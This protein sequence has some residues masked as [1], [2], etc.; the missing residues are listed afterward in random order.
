MK[1]LLLL[2]PLLVLA[3]CR[4]HD[5][6]PPPPPSCLISDVFHT[7]FT[8]AGA[9]KFTYD[10][11]G[12][13]LRSVESDSILTTFT[14]AADSVVANTTVNNAFVLRTITHNNKDGLAT[15]LRATYNA[16]GTLWYHLTYEYN[17]QQVIRSSFTAST[18]P[19]TQITTFTWSGGNMVSLTS[20]SDTNSTT[21]KWEYYTDQPRQQ[22]DAS[23]FDQFTGGFEIIRNKNLL[24]SRDGVAYT[25]EF[26]HDGKIGAVTGRDSIGDIFISKYDYDCK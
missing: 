12:R 14:Y 17:G 21:E 11:Q 7:G 24:K 19:D 5:T 6:P 22:G 26:I 23:F 13:I 10:S 2:T 20:V 1:H 18:R 25:Y 8:N 9:T 15:S 4:K 16:E 3:A